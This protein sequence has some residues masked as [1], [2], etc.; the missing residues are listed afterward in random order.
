MSKTQTAR[1]R[2][3]AAR[4]KKQAA[5]EK[6]EKTIQEI[7]MSCE[8]PEE[9]V[10][11][12]WRNNE[13][14]YEPPYFVC[15]LCGYAEERDGLSHHPSFLKL[16]YRSLSCKYGEDEIKARTYIFGQIKSQELLDRVYSQKESFDILYKGKVW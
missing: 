1:D 15:K 11:E 10:L 7:Q 3:S 13:W 12:A 8:H 2:I 5:I 14:T 4:K 16:K 9:E 6:Y